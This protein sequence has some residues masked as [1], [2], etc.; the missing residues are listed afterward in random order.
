MLNR[1]PHAIW[2]NKN[3]LH[4]RY[5]ETVAYGTQFILSKKVQENGNQ[6][7]HVGYATR[8]CSMFVFYNKHM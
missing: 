3:E 2:G 8:T 6:T 7:V 4:S 5:T 1:Q